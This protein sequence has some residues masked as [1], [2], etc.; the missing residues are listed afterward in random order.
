MKRILVCLMLS[1]F[2]ASALLAQGGNRRE[3]REQKKQQMQEMKIAFIKERVKLSAEEEKAFWPLYTEYVSQKQ[4]LRENLRKSKRE[5]KRGKSVD[6]ESLN[7]LAV[8]AELDEAA[9]LSSFY[10]KIKKILPAEKI[11]QFYEAEKDFKKELL[12]KVRES[13]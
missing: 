4:G 3:Q 13:K 2:F 5:V 11:F 6:Y 7:D 10:N 1:A 9:L 8:K 12:D